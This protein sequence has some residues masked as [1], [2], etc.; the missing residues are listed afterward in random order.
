MG[1]FEWIR[2]PAPVCGGCIK[3]QQAA[4]PA[5]PLKENLRQIIGQRIAIEAARR[6]IFEHAKPV[7]G[8]CDDR[9]FDTSKTAPVDADTQFRVNRAATFLDLCGLLERM[10]GAPHIVAIKAGAA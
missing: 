3:P 8:A 5:D 10:G 4:E 6:E 9:W 1:L 2:K 7:S